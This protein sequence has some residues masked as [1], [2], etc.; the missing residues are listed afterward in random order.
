MK[1]KNNHKEEKPIKIKEPEKRK[2]ISRDTLDQYDYPI[3]CFK[4]FNDT[5]I[6]KCKDSKFFIDFLNRLQKLSDLGWE[7]IRKSGKHQYGM[8]K[9]PIEKI[10][11]QV[12]SFLTPDVTKLD[13]FRATGSNHPFVGFLN[14]TVFQVFFIETE[15]GDIY[16]H[17]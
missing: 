5:S 4:Y 8:E 3:F 15:F 6:K 13:V 12:P 14:K 9:I 11:P 17:E 2:T 1:K 7:E 16:D 10:K